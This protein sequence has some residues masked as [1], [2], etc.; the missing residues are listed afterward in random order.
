MEFGADVKK[1]ND[2]YSKNKMLRTASISAQ[3]VKMG[4]GSH[5]FPILFLLSFGNAT[6]FA[7]RMGLGGNKYSTLLAVL[8]T[9]P[10]T[11][12]IGKYAFGVKKFREVEQLDKDLA[13]SASY[14]E[15]HHSKLI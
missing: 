15:A 2:D 1:M 8:F 3:E 14:Y 10:A 9:V 5:F 11:I 13:S 12:F 6:I 7:Y 4:H